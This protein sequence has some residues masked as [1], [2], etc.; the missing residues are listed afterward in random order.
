MKKRKPPELLAVGVRDF[1]G[2]EIGIGSIVEILERG[3]ER[4]YGLYYVI[5]FEAGPRSVRCM[6]ARARN[7]KPV[8][9]ASPSR[10]HLRCY[11]PIR[12]KG[13]IKL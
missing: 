13:E 7:D 6:L 11:E 12:H 10:L 5:A 8:L 3:S 1:S 4:F 9:T 2:E